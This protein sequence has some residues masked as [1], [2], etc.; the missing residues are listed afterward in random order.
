MSSHRNVWRPQ[1]KGD[2][3]LAPRAKLGRGKHSKILVSAISGEVIPSGTGARVRL[4]FRDPNKPT[5]T[6]HVTDKGGA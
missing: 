2:E 6:F 5:R 1:D 3:L 4:R